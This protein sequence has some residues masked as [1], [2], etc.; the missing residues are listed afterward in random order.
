[1][2]SDSAVLLR[3]SSERASQ[4][5]VEMLLAQAL[6]F[7]G[8]EDDAWLARARAFAAL[9]SEGESNLLATSVG[10]AIKTELAG[11]RR[12]AALAL[13]ALALSIARAGSQPQLVI[14]ALVNRSRL[15]SMSGHPA[16]A[17]QSARHAEDIA[18]GTADA[19]LR[20]RNLAIVAVAIGSA[21]AETDPRAAAEPLTRAIDFNE[22][23]NLP[24][25]LLEPL[26]LRSRCAVRTGD[27]AAAMRDLERGMAIV[28]SHPPAL[29][30]LVVSEDVLDSEH[31]LF[32]DA[33]RLSL[34]RNETAAAFAFA[35]RSRGSAVTLAELQRRLAGSG[36]VVLE[37][38]AL[39]EELIM[40]AVAE[41]D[42]VVARRTRSS[43]TLAL[44]ADESLSESGTTAAA[45]LYD[46]VIRPVDSVLARAREVVIVP[47]RHLASTPFAAL[48]DSSLRRYLIERFAVS[49]ASSAG[50]LSPE[51]EHSGALSLVAITLPT[52]DAESV[53]LPEA[54]REARDVAAIYTHAESIPPARATLA[55]LRSAAAGADVVHIA[56]HTERQP[57]GGEQALLFA[58]TTGRPERVSWKTIVVQPP[59]HA[60]LIVLAACETLRAPASAATHS[61]S[62]GGAF[63]AAGAAGVVG[64]LAPIGDHDARLLFGALHRYLV[65]GARPAEALRAAQLE[66]MTRDKTN[67]GRRAWGAVALLTRRI[68][69]PSSR[70]GLRS[71]AN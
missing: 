29:G 69:A 13:S 27:P 50:S 36:T 2:L 56:G 61:L 11:G 57:G 1:V 8:R 12:E 63:S 41:N 51:T 45:T 39:P 35:E 60:G 68:P 66:A 42:V 32:E 33:I 53:A 9:S 16:D 46:D 26:L 3:R 25:P 65:S 47:D 31:A 21:L 64:T 70:K 55:T 4:A 52:G 54:E 23:H 67:D 38:V 7:L 28:E 43:D 34:G 71:W 22:Q 19:A 49:I 37:I 18:K 24:F 62:L 10:G 20:A 48:Y 15:E 14:E 30:G 17:L 6:S 40:F 44:L 59:M 58:G 5:F